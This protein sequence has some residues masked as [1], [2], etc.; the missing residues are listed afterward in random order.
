MSVIE[1]LIAIQQHVIA[2][3]PLALKRAF[4]S[5]INWKARAI[6]LKGGRGVGKTTMLCQFLVE[7]YQDASR[8]L[9]VSA[10]NINVLSSG[11]FAIAQ[12]YF[13]FGGE[14]LFIDEIHKYPNWQ[15]ET[16]NIIDTYRTK[17]IIF[18]GSSSLDLNKS[19]YDLSRRVVY[20]ELRGL[21][22]REYLHF[23]LDQQ[24]PVLTLDQILKDHVAI[25]DQFKE[26]P[27]L[28]YF[29]E[30]LLLGY[31]PFFLEG[32]EDYI[33]KVNNIIEKVIFEDIAMVYNL[34]QST[35]VILKKILWLVATSNGLLPN[36][37][38]ISKNLAVSREI[39]YQCLDYLDSAGLLNNIHPEA[40]GMKLIR[41]PGKIYLENTSLLY[42][43]HGGLKL[44]SDTGGV[45]ETFFVNQVSQK[46]RLNFYDS[47]D[48]IVDGNYVFEVG[49]K[50]KNF[51]QIKN[52]NNSFLAI[53]NIEVGFARKIPLYLFG[54]LY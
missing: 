25:A 5:E 50:G 14:A 27:I 31:Y 21:S 1:E 19:K 32:K 11:L 37:D 38:R 34:R 2:T 13:K 33:A 6:C 39:V 35:L 23:S 4:F 36:I 54:F 51:Q 40:K 24:W 49:G 22:F 8:A 26:I 53:D 41:K 3:T 47:G 20:Y 17:Q 10:D 29:K 46:H 18:S 42:G 15:Q 45:R 7:H 43:I 44:P 9:Y 30:Y 48:Y 52:V 28:K 16:K 12:E